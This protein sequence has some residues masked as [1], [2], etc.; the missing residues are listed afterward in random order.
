[1]LAAL[2]EFLRSPIGR[3]L[4]DIILAAI[5]GGVAAS[6]LREPT[7]TKFLFRGDGQEP[8][9]AQVQA[10]IG[11]LSMGRSGCTGTIIGPV[12]RSDRSVMVLT[13]A[14]CIKLGEQ[15][16]M[17]L[18]DGRE[19]KLKCVAR[20]AD[21]DAAWL[22]G[23]RPDGKVPFAMLADGPA[24]AGSKVWHCGFGVHVPGNVERGEV[25]NEG[26][27]RAQV[28]YRLSVSPG[29]SGGGI[30]LDRTSRV[31]SPVCCTTRLSS[32]GTVYGASPA[33]CRALLEGAQVAADPLSTVHPIQELPHPDWPLPVE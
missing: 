4:I 3:R 11:R 21:S 31:L 6:E 9:F 13:A 27:P 5:V 14:H 24:P 23:D 19:F 1:M 32:V 25:V 15:A 16:R 28:A 7:F 22:K 26:A 8:D 10:A 17:R 20:D 30:I 18:R 2:L 29:D 12:R 33:A